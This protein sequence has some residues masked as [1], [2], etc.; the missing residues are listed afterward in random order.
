MMGKY[1]L[2]VILAAC[3][4]AIVTSLLDE[5][6]NQGVLLRMIGGLFLAFTVITPVLKLDFEGA[7][8]IV[9]DY[10]AE[11]DDAARRGE[12]LATDAMGEIIKEQTEAY[13]LDKANS[14]GATVCVSVEVSEDPVPIPVSACLEGNVTPYAKW[15]LQRMLES[16]LGIPKENQQWIG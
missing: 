7:I 1:I 10:M 6:T 4:V 9:D 3:V 8:S 11:A 15:Q 5:K 13:I 16:D 12:D 14:Y 2:S